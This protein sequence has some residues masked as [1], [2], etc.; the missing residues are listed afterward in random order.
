MS[1]NGLPE[2]IPIYVQKCALPAFWEEL[3]DRGF[4]NTYFQ[5][6]TPKQIYGKIVTTQ[7]D[8]IESE[9]HIRCLV[10]GSQNVRIIGEFEPKRL[11]SMVQHLSQHSY[12]AHEYIID[13]LGNLGIRYKVDQ[14]SRVHYN[15]NRLKKF[16]KQKF[17]FFNWLFKGVFLTLPRGILWRAY[18][19]I[20]CR[21][22]KKSLF[23]DC[24]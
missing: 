16:T 24:N 4:R 8:G 3:K 2:H 17:K 22:K 5:I 15:E 18:F 1:S 21:I 13:T 20:S 6:F 11:G 9:L 12:S 10:N 23:A 7:F 19:E 14:T